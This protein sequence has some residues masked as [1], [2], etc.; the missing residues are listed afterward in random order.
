MSCVLKKELKSQHD[1]I[2][3]DR[4]SDTQYECPVLTGKKICLWCCLHIEGVLNPISRA[5][6]EEKYRDYVDTISDMSGL[7]LDAAWEICSSCRNR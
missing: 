7:N 4:F 6:L 1:K 2:Q 5:N 3:D